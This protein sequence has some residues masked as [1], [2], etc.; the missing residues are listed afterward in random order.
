M[1]PEELATPIKSNE[2]SNCLVD[3]FDA[4]EDTTLVMDAREICEFAHNTI[5]RMW[6]ELQ[7]LR[8]ESAKLAALEAGGV[9]NWGVST[10]MLSANTSWTQ[11][12]KVVSTGI[13][14]SNVSLDW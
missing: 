12:E 4:T 3:L 6:F 9:D 10:L 13:V 5:K 2:V 1:S 11:L 7:K 14:L 8:V